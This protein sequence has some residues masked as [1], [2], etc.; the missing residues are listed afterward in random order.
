MKRIKFIFAWY[1]LWIGLFFSTKKKLIYIFP[2]PCLGI[3]VSYCNHSGKPYY[4]DH[5]L[6]CAKCSGI[7]K[8]YQS[9]IL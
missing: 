9:K 3:I 8:D 7:I 5:K 4:D 6:K 2:I 1:D